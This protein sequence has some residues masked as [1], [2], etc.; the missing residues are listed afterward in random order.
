MDEGMNASTVSVLSRSWRY[1]HRQENV[2]V[3]C[4]ITYLLQMDVTL[5]IYENNIHPYVS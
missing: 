1:I 5:Q 4:C 2:F 3:Q